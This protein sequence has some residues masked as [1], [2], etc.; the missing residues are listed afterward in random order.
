MA[1]LVVCVTQAVDQIRLRKEAWS[2]VESMAERE[3]TTQQLEAGINKK[4]ALVFV[5]N[6][7]LYAAIVLLVAEMARTRGWL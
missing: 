3:D 5:Q 4:M 1:V 2:E 6:V 7:V